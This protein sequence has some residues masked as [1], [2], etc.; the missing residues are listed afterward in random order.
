MHGELVFFQLFLGQVAML[1][2]QMQIFSMCLRSLVWLIKALD[3]SCGVTV[4][5]VNTVTLEGLRLVLEF[6]GDLSRLHV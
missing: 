6:L 4:L 2:L 3:G 5:S 1:E